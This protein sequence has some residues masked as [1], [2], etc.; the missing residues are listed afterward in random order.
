MPSKNILLNSQLRVYRKN[1]TKIKISQISQLRLYDEAILLEEFQADKQLNF[2][3][4]NLNKAFSY[5]KTVEI[6]Y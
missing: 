4:T 1:K 6:I 2:A 5:F 3:M